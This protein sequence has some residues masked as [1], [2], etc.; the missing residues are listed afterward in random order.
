LVINVNGHISDKLVQE[1]REMGKKGV[2]RGRVLLLNTCYHPANADLISELIEKYGAIAVLNNG[3]RVEVAA[4]QEVLHEVPAVLREAGNEGLDPSELFIRA[5]ERALENKML[6]PTLRVQIE[7]LL[8]AP[9]QLSIVAPPIVN[10]PL[11]GN[12][13]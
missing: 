4:L 5:A 12:H 6:S 9:L 2:L 1:L 3:A 10:N 7:W 8:R 13:G 11:R